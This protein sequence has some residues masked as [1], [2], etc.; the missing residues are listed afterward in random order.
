MKQVENILQR[1]TMTDQELFAELLVEGLGEE[2]GEVGET[3]DDV[4][5]ERA[6]VTQH[7][8]QRAHRGVDHLY[9]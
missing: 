4:Q 9:L 3:L 8:E 6:V 2:L 7:Q 5:V 1:V